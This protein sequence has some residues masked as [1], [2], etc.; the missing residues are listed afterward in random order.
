MTS[1]LIKLLKSIRHI[2]GFYNYALSNN[3]DKIPKREDKSLIFIAGKLMFREA[4]G[5]Y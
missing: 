3:L 5:F 2:A 4:K 1:L